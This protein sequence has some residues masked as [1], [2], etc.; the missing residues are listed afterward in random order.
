MLIDKEY[1][2]T[3]S[4]TTAWYMVDDDGNIA[5]MQADDNGPVPF[6]VM[7]EGFAS[8]IL[9]GEGLDEN[10]KCGPIELTKE[11]IEETLGEKYT[12]RSVKDWW[13]TVVEIDTSRID[14][15]MQIIA[16]SSIDYEGCVSKKLGLYKIDAIWCTNDDNTIIEGSAL[17]RLVSSGI[18][19]YVY[20]IPEMEMDCDYNEKSRQCI[21]TKEFDSNSYYIYNQP[22]WP[23]FIQKRVNIPR[24]PVKI[25]QVEES[26]REKIL[27]IPGKFSDREY[28]QIAEW[29]PCKV[30]GYSK[31][32]IIDGYEYSM[33]PMPDGT[34][35][36]V[37]AELPNDAPIENPPKHSYSKEEVKELKKRGLA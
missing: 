24:H 33:L 4:M 11:Q 2:A 36:Y 16:D 37:L 25:D 18:I 8:N 31:A 21:F 19:R 7:P 3:H 20:K 28:M 10:E 23:N 12:P 35:K 22:Y 15:F 17:D 34:E 29:Y 1:P 13:D 27:H 6:G 30:C 26:K 9:F 32:V 14:S 5:I